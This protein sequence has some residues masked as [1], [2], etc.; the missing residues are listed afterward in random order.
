MVTSEGGDA[1]AGLE[2]Y[3]S[4]RG[5]DLPHVTTHAP[6]EVSSIANVVYLAGDRRTATPAA[7]FFLHRP[8]LGD[9]N[10]PGSAESLATLSIRR[11]QAERANASGTTLAVLDLKIAYL[12]TL[13]R[14]IQEV[15]ADRTSMSRTEV[16]VLMGDEKTLDA[17]EALAAGIVHEIIGD[18]A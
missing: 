2:L 16:A 18:S 6:G 14:D 8:F 12:R 13:E 17:N 9:M 15:V 7:E 5:A 1:E 11:A 10:D 3:E 4:I